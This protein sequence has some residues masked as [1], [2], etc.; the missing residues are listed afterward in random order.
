[1][2]VS[3][4]LL[5]GL[6]IDWTPGFSS[7][8]VQLEG[9]YRLNSGIFCR[10]TLTPY[11]SAVIGSFRQ[12]M[13]TIL[14]IQPKNSSGETREDVVYRMA[15]DLQSKLLP[16]FLRHEVRAML[17]KMEHLQPLNFFLLQEID[18]MQRVTS[19]V[20]HRGDHH[21]VREPA[22]RA[23]LH[24]RRAG[25]V[26]LEE[27]LV[28]VRHHRVLFTVPG[29]ALA[30]PRLGLLGPAAPVLDDQLLQP[31]GLPHRQAPG[32]HAGA[33]QRGSLQRDHQARPLPRGSTCTG[34]TWRAP[35]GTDAT[36]SWWS[37]STRCSTSRYQWC[38]STPSS[39]GRQPGQREAIL[40]SAL[41][42]AETDGPDLHLRPLPEDR[43]PPGPLDTVKCRAP[44]RLQVICRSLCY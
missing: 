23:G 32:G 39:L 11:S 7:S 10:I 17:H 6:P 22:G 14:S 35:G 2:D 15:E 26:Q 9:K 44:L 34:C 24:V 5:A 21:H 13:G 20:R 42:E 1:M 30:V 18:R 40:V 27:D 28:G 12:V 3:D 36:A 38:T 25:A 4:Y 29:A 19:A 33:G 43:T 16:N 37:P 41:Q 8:P 31:A